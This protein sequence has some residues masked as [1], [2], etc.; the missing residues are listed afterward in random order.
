MFGEFSHAPELLVLLVLALLV[1]GSKN[2]PDLGRGLGEALGQFR[3]AVSG[4][5]A[6]TEHQQPAGPQP[7]P[8]H[9]EPVHRAEPGTG[10]SAG[11]A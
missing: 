5:E 7:K 10:S 3:R 4:D 8:P 9:D 11:P 2:L 6:G 1:F